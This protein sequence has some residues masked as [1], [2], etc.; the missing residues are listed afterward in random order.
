MDKR[1]KDTNVFVSAATSAAWVLFKYKSN[2]LRASG[3][4]PGH[5][6]LHAHELFE[7]RGRRCSPTVC[8]RLHPVRRGRTHC[9]APSSCTHGHEKRLG[10]RLIL[11]G[12][13][14]EFPR[15][16]EVQ[17]LAFVAHADDAQRWAHGTQVKVIL[18]IGRGRDAHGI[19]HSVQVHELELV[20]VLERH[21]RPNVAK[22]SVCH[23][24]V[25][26]NLG[27]HDHGTKD[28]AAPRRSLEFQAPACRG[29]EPL[30]VHERHDDTLGV[31]LGERQDALHK[32]CEVAHRGR[33]VGVLV[34]QS[35]RRRAG[36]TGGWGHKHGERRDG[37]S[38]RRSGQIEFVLF[39]RRRRG[40]RVGTL[41]SDPAV[42][43][44]GSR[45]LATSSERPRGG[46]PPHEARKADV[47]LGEHTMSRQSVR[48]GVSSYDESVR[49][50]DGHLRS[51]SSVVS[52]SC[53]GW[54]S[55]TLSGVVGTDRVAS[56]INCRVEPGKDRAEPLVYE[57][58]L[59]RV[60]AVLVVDRVEAQEGDPCF[61]T[62][63]VSGESC[64]TPRAPLCSSRTYEP[65]RNLT[66][67]LFSMT[68]KKCFCSRVSAARTSAGFVHVVSRVIGW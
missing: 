36:R 66:R 41:L 13:N 40:R 24:Q 60:L 42:V 27:R 52:G 48:T 32:G 25:V 3:T 51:S 2:R 15:R 47:T 9:H 6:H 17:R 8:H 12:Q 7:T 28:H 22:I 56:R 1:Y 44:H 49:N 61:R 29:Q 16:V 31:H 50:M 4:A 18:G 23:A 5:A 10:P 64:P 21:V 38:A 46:G 65:S 11:I 58:R 34:G 20:Q 67:M 53:C 63:V 37:R 33:M 14:L 43:V 39:A 45:E 26:P 55:T 35:G 54:G 57:L 30:D 59:L 62:L 19:V 68:A